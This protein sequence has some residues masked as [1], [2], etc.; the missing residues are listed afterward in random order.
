[1]AEIIRTV[2]VEEFDELMRFLEVCFG[3]SKGW[4]ERHLPHIYRPLPEICAYGYVIEKNSKIV[5]HVG[6]YPIETMTAGV[7]L[8]IGGIGAV[9][10]LPEERG[11]GYMTTLLH[12]AISE[13]RAQG[14]ALSWLGGDRQRY[15]SFGWER[16][17][18]GYTLTFSHRSLDQAKI[19]PA[20]IEEQY[21]TDVAEVIEKLYS[22]PSC[23][24]I[25]PHLAVQ[26]R[27]VDLRA[28]TVH[29]PGDGAVNGYAIARATER[30]PALI[31]EIVSTTGCEASIIRAI[32]NR[33]DLSNASW[34]MSVWDEERLA[35]LM[36]HVSGYR[37]GDGCMYRIV[38]LCRL[39]RAAHPH[40]ARRAA[41]VRDFAVAIG[42]REHDR[43]DEA[44]IRVQDG[45]VEIERGRNAGL[46]VEAPAVEAARLFMGGP[47]T[48]AHA[49][50]PAG[51][52]ALLP[53]PAWVPPL[54]Y[55]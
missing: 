2:R 4:F 42:I 55:V 1:M 46:Y 52:M 5:S 49:W 8:K 53:I 33:T 3:A 32:L 9:S 21:L 14:Y 25:R 23:H 27:Q 18:P 36:P 26:M 19:E 39:L 54:D 31:V 40:L 34:G 20:K 10:T 38:D 43:V 24:V 50:L 47:P 41:G 44:T 11:H 13:M 7:R 48:S 12:H 6:V 17:N 45:A 16:V 29:D 28:W 15:N 22:V 30:A 51:L 35:R 37:S